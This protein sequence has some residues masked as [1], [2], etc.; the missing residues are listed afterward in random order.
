MSQVSI[1]TGASLAA[2]DGQFIMK[3]KNGQQIQIFSFS[4]LL[5]ELGAKTLEA[6]QMAFQSQMKRSEAMVKCM[7][8]LNEIM[9]EASRLKGQ[10]PSTGDSKSVQSDG[11]LDQMIREFNANYPD[12]TI[13]AT[14]KSPFSNLLPV[15]LYSEQEISS[16]VS[17][18]QTTQSLVS[19]FNE[20]QG[21]RTSQ[22][23]SRAS[24]F[25]QQLQTAMQSARECLTAAA[26]AGAV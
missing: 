6:H 23:M 19:S 4:S 10:L 5:V 1:P 11:S 8:E 22:A 7:E 17:N 18:L 16:L 20:Q 26:K 25:L 3:D 2:T 21:T 15:V 24:G 9:Q 12:F 14:E 13:N